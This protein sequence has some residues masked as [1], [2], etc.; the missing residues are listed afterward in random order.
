MANYRVLYW[1]R[2]PS[3]VE[4]RDDQGKKHKE[5]LSSRFQELIDS[6]AMRQKLVGTDAYLEGWRRGRPRERDGRA[7]DVAKAVAAELEATFDEVALAA[8]G[9]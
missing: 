1:H 2:I 5:Q 7:E 9:S 8:R 3:V 4:A 6:I